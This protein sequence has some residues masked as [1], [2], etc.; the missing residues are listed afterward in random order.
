MSVPRLLSAK[1]EVEGPAPLTHLCLQTSGSA[2]QQPGWPPCRRRPCPCGWHSRQGAWC[3]SVV[4]HP[5]RRDTRSDG[6]HSPRRPRPCRR[7]AWPVG[8]EG[9]GAQGWGLFKL[10][11]SGQFS[12]V[13]FLW[14]YCVPGL[15]RG[16]EEGKMEEPGSPFL[17]LS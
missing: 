11:V 13:F 7:W 15:V 14:T 1:K 12:P 8:R 3:P 2:H 6:S 16:T 17:V 5:H 9:G 4:T 10:L